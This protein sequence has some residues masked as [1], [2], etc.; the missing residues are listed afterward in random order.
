MLPNAARAPRSRVWGGVR[1]SLFGTTDEALEHHLRVGESA[2][3]RREALRRMH[4]HPHLP[5]PDLVMLMRRELGRV[6]PEDVAKI[7]DDVAF[8]IFKP[9]I[10]GVRKIVHR[11]DL[12][13]P[14]LQPRDR[15]VWVDVKKRF[16]RRRRR[17]SGLRHLGSNLPQPRE[18]VLPLKISAGVA[19]RSFSMSFAG[20]LVRLG[21]PVSACCREE[22]HRKEGFRSV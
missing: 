1:N 10:I 22:E 21:D 20:T 6:L 19:P 5:L 9:W 11:S 13:D 16:L 14:S 2:A 7:G 8:G 15:S 18:G 3:S 12:N 4:A 17:S